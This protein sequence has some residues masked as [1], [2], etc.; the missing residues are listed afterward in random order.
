MFD[1]GLLGLLLKGMTISSLYQSKRIMFLIVLI[2]LID[3][4]DWLIILIDLIDW[5][6]S[7]VQPIED[8]DALSNMDIEISFVIWNG[9]NE[10]EK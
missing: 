3:L 6:G 8:V 7:R 4:I 5:F 10:W 2:I 1:R 9:M